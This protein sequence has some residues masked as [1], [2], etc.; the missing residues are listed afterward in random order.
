MKSQA[1]SVFISSARKFIHSGAVNRL[2]NLIKNLHGADIAFLLN[3]LTFKEKLALTKILLE[4]NKERAADALS[5]L[6]PEDAAEILKE[7]QVGQI[8]DLF[9]IIASDDVAPI[10]PHL[11]EEMQDSVLAQMEK[12]PSEDVRE[13]LHHEEE[14]AGR[15]MSTEF[16]ALEQDTKVA[17]AVTALKL[18]EEVE[19]AFYLYAVDE[20]GRLVGVVSLRQLLFAHAN[21]SLKDI[22]TR[23][24]ISVTPDTDQEKVARCVADYNLVAIPVADAENKLVGVV[25]VDDVI[26]VINKEAT[27]DIYK[28]VALSSTDRLSDSPKKSIKKRLPF[29]LLSLLT[30]S[31]APLVINFFKG[32]IQEVVI[33]AV[34]MPLIAAL[35]G[36][37]GSQTIA[38]MVREIAVGEADWP[39][40]K[41][42]LMKE[43]AVGVGNGVVVGLVL[44]LVSYLLIGIP[45]LGFILGVAVVINLFLAALLGTLIPLILK[46]LKLDPALGSHNLLTMCTDAVGMLSFLGLGS[47]FLHHLK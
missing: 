10:L 47:L 19:S 9:D 22:M 37:A 24:V 14:T 7:L 8:S 1:E 13:L 17:D 2:C 32:T 46:L 41:R 28:M 43:I 26:D 30:A 20:V 34:F 16:Y 44:A 45:A 3:R 21:S 5:E 35:G 29:L 40:A 11:P 25:T 27:E 18:E 12:E 42:A 15:I 39:G 33:L 38:I 31:L 4:Q 6:N 36:I 23:N